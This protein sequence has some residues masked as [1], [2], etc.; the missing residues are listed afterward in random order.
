MTAPVML[1]AF[2]CERLGYS[3]PNP[4][5]ASGEQRSTTLE[6][7]RPASPVNRP[8]TDKMG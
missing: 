4:G 3:A 7:L 8:A 2:L 6:F 1:R 5:C